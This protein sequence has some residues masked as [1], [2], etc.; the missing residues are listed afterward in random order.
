MTPLHLSRAPSGTLRRLFVPLGMRV[1]ESYPNA[2]MANLALLTASNR[3]N[4]A[5]HMTLACTRFY[6]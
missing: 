3:M 5:A 4:A 1:E 6:V 2:A